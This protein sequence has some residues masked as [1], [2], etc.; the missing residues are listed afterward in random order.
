MKFESRNIRI[1]N[2]WTVPM[3]LLNKNG[4]DKITRKAGIVNCGPH[5]LWSHMWF[6]C[7]ACDCK[8][9]Y[10][11]TKAFLP[12]VLLVG[13]PEVSTCSIHAGYMIWVSNSSRMQALATLALVFRCKNCK[14]ILSTFKEW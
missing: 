14:T 2:C 11:P 7:G 13:H 12:A 10:R 5:A 6:S 1:H 4:A 9:F 3:N 8:N